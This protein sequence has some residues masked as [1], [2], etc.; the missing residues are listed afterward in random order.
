MCYVMLLFIK[1]VHENTETGLLKT[2]PLPPI[3]RWT[4]LKDKDGLML[5][6]EY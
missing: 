2:H 4:D 6:N 3:C 5:L 1:I